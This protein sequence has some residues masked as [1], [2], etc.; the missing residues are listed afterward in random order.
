M[1]RLRRMAVF[2]EVVEA[3]SMTAAGE[4]LGMSASAVSQ[5]VR[6]LERQ[7]G[8]TLLHRSTRKLTLTEAG[9]RF[10]AGCAE[11]LA[12]AQRA[13][14]AVERLRDAPEGELRLAAPAGLAQALAA[15]LAPLLAAHAP[16][17]LRLLLDDM[18]ID[19]IDARIDLALR[20]GAF[21]DSTLVTRRIGEIGRRL[22]AAPSYLARR[23]EPRT[24]ADLAAHDWLGR[25]ASAAG[26]TLELQSLD[27]GM[28]QRVRLA[29]PRVTSTQQHALH[30]FCVA[31]LGLATAVEP[32]VGAELAAGRLVPVL[33]RWRLDPLPLH[34]VTPR[35]DAQPAKVR[36]AIDA[37]RA[38]FSP[39]HLDAAAAMRATASEN[40]R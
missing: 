21:A 6:A 30:A 29:P 26:A 25:E 18:P 2:A 28:R 1:D 4:R 39:Q 32:D 37:L 27:D 7:L 8:T 23:G 31:G 14:Q 19:L 17:R 33:P 13:E 12:A 15:G 3:G 34:A 36:L 16:L 9:M 24:P 40:R 11:M 5:Q 35:R 38:L 22:V 20:V 10:H